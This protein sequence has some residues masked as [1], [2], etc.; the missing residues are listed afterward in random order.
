MLNSLINAHFKIK[1]RDPH[2]A[3]LNDIVKAN[4]LKQLM[5]LGQQS[6]ANAIV[7]ALVHEQLVALDRWLAGQEEADFSEFY[8]MQ[9]DRYFD[10][11]EDFMA[12]A[13]N[14]LPDGS[15]IGSFSCDF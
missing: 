12:P 6:S 14:R 11:P 8:R 13:P 10:S 9:I 4:V 2:L 3:Q 5:Y 7:K 1:F 15:P